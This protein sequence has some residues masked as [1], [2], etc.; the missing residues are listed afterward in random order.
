MHFPDDHDHIYTEEVV[1]TIDP[2]KSKPQV[3]RSKHGSALTRKPRNT[4]GKCN[5]GWMSQIETAVIAVATPL[6]LGKPYL[7]DTADQWRLAT[8]LCL[9]SMRIAFLARNSMAI[10]DVDRKWLMQRCE[11]PPHWKIWI[12][13]IA[14]EPLDEHWTLFSAIKRQKL[15]L[16]EVRADAP[17]TQCTTIVIGQ[18]CGHLFSAISDWGFDGYDGIVLTDIWPPTQFYIDTRFIPTATHEVA[19]ALHNAFRLPPSDG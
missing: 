12:A 1:S 19:R 11:P 10:S 2:A 9:I 8:F 7:I 5:G 17:N 18:L 16:D 14:D 15:P 13:R 6:I 3:R 4:C